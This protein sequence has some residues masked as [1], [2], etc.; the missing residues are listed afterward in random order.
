MFRH[1]G[2]DVLEQLRDG[3]CVL[4][5]FATPPR[6]GVFRDGCE[7]YERPGDGNRGVVFSAFSGL[8]VYQLWVVHTVRSELV[9]NLPRHAHVQSLVHFGKVPSRGGGLFQRRSAGGLPSLET[10]LLRRLVG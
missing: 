1:Q 8:R 2:F 6:V 7:L 3:D 5:V 4:L 9:K 10:R